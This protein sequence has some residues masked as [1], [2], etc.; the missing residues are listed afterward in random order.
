MKALCSVFHPS[1]L[2]SSSFVAVVE[3]VA[4]VERRSPA[5]CQLVVLVAAERRMCLARSC[6]V[7]GAVMPGRVIFVHLL[8]Q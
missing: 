4:Q 5:A 6:K 1:G 8:G 2:P 7:C 3:V